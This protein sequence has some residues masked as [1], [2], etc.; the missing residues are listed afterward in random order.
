MNFGGIRSSNEISVSTN[1]SVRDS[2]LLN[3]EKNDNDNNNSSNNDDENHDNND[4]IDNVNILKRISEIKIDKDYSSNEN[5]GGNKKVDK[6][7]LIGNNVELKKDKN[8]FDDF[9]TESINTK[10]L[11]VFNIND[12]YKKE[13]KNISLIPYF[14]SDLFVSTNLPPALLLPDLLVST[15]R[16]LHSCSQYASLLF[17]HCFLNCF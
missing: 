4:R 14:N 9:N 7:V 10:K 16:T 1:T 17:S 15:V 12:D 13:N 8:I 6:I 11:K 2:T 3:F 5:D